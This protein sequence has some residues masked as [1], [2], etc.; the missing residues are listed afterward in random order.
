MAK[1]N[2]LSVLWPK[3]YDTFAE[4]ESEF[5]LCGDLCDMHRVQEM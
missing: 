2:P 1:M 5:S 3:S 4:D